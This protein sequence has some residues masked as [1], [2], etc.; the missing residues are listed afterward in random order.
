M[1]YGIVLWFLMGIG[2]LW[3]LFRPLELELG[4]YAGT[5]KDY[6]PLAFYNKLLKRGI[7][8]CHRISFEVPH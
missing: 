4:G 8:F 1:A 5:F 7:L 3:V 2:L 6:S